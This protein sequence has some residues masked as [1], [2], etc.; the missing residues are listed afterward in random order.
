MEEGSTHNPINEG[1]N[2]ELQVT[3]NDF[4]A[5]QHKGR[6]RLKDYLQEGL[7]IFV[8]VVMGFLAENVREGIGNR[9]KEGQ[10]MRSYIKNLEQDST[11]LQRSIFDNNHKIIYLDSLISFS[12]KDI[13]TVSN[14]V[15]FYYFCIRTIGYYSEFSNNDA[16]FLQLTNSGGLRLIKKDHVADSIAEYAARLKNIYGAEGV[17]AKATE[18]ATMAAHEVLDFTVVYDSVYYKLDRPTGVFI[19]LISEDKQKVKLLY[20]RIS[21]ERA[22]TQN[23]VNELKSLNP[24]LNRFIAYLREQYLNE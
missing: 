11:M 14:R 10:Y 24:F 12:R 19:P 15:A 5:S 9:E 8:A 3:R 16:T 21:F 17:Y 7:M 13:S 20:N 2:P 22:A 1:Q 23:Y 18:A 4:E 6:K